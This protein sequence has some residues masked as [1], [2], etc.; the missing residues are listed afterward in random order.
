MRDF[1]IR[2]KAQY[3]YG[4]EFIRGKDNKMRYFR[5]LRTRMYILLKDLLT[6]YIDEDRLYMCM[7]SNEVWEDVF[8]VYG[9]TSKR[10]ADRLDK[11]C[12]T[13]FSRLDSGCIQ[14]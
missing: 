4:G 8:G 1:M 14:G 10:L 9:M 3:I 11:A 7:E 6:Q 2:K 13:K 5:P 12:Y